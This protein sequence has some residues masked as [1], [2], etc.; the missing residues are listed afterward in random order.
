[1]SPSRFICCLSMLGML[2]AGAWAMPPVQQQAGL[3]RS[4]ADLELDYQVVVDAN[5]L[6]MFVTNVGS[7]ARDNSSLMGRI[8]GLY[9]PTGY[10]W[11]ALYSGGLWLGA[12]VAGSVRVSVAG[13]PPHTYSPGPMKDGTY[14]PDSSA[15]KVYKISRELYE[16][17]FYGNPRPATNVQ[18]QEKWDNYH[19]WP[20]SMGA[21]TY[22][23]G[24][25]RFYGDQT[26]WC[27]F[28]D[29]DPSTHY[30]KVGSSVG[31]G[32]EIQQTTF[33]LDITN[34]LKH[35]IFVRYLLINKGGNDLDSMYAT[36]WADPDIGD[37]KD[38]LAGCDTELDLGYAYNAK[39]VDSLYGV[40]P[41]AVGFCLLNGPLVPSAADS[42]MLHWE[43]RQG[44]RNLPMTAFIGTIAD[45][46]PIADQESYWYMQGLDA[47]NEGSAFLEPGTPYPTTFLFSGD[48]VTGSGWVD[49]AAI[50]N[51]SVSIAVE[52]TIHDW[53]V[54]IIPPR[55]VFES[56]DFYCTW[57]ISSDQEG[58]RSR[59]DYLGHIGTGT[60][61]MQI[62]SE[63]YGSL[64]YDWDTHYSTAPTHA[65]FEVWN[66]GS[67]LESYGDDRRLEIFIDDVV[68]DGKWSPGDIIYFWEEDYR[69]TPP[70]MVTP[71]D[72]ALRIGRIIIN[73][74]VPLEGNTIR[75]TS[76]EVA[77]TL[78]GADG[79]YMVSAGPFHMAPGDTQ[80]V[81]FAV[82]VGAG[83]DYLQSVTEL[84]TNT[85]AVQAAWDAGFDG[86]HFMHPPTPAPDTTLE[87]LAGEKIS[88]TVMAIDSTIGDT[89]AFAVDGLPSG[90]TLT[91]ALPLKG[92]PVT[93]TFSWSPDVAQV[94]VHELTFSVIDQNTGFTERYSIKINVTTP[95]NPSAFLHPPTP[96]CDTAFHLVAGDTLEFTVEAFDEDKLD[97]VTLT[98][99]GLPRG[100]QLTPALPVTDNPVQTSLRWVP[101]YTQ[102]G[103]H[104]LT[105]SIVDPTGAVADTCSFTV[106]VSS[107]GLA[108]EFVHPPTPACDTT[109]T[110]Q[111]GSMV[112]FSVE[113]NDQ[114]AA[115]RVTLS[116][117]GIPSGSLLSNPL[118]VT[119]NP[120]TTALSWQPDYSQLGS[121]KID[122]VIIDSIDGLSA[123]CSITLNVVY[124]GLPPLFAHPPTPECDTTFIIVARD[125]VCFTVRAYDEIAADRVT[126]SANGLPASAVVRPVLPA[127]G[128]P[129]SAQLCWRP[130]Y[131]DLGLYATTF[132]AT[133]SIDGLSIQ[134][135]FNFEV[136]SAGIAPE[137]RH[138]PT[139]ACDTTFNVNVGDTVEFAVEVVDSIDV[140]TVTLSAEGLPENAVITPELPASGNPVQ[141]SFFW[142]PPAADVGRYS[143][144]FTVVD[145]I[146]DLSAACGIGIDV[147]QNT[148]E[149]ESVTPADT[150]MID[151]TFSITF[152][153]P[154]NRVSVNN[155]EANPV[156]DQSIEI[157][158]SYS[159]ADDDRTIIFHPVN[160]LPPVT[161]LQVHLSGVVG[162]EGQT[163]APGY[164]RTVVFQTGYGVFPGDLNNDGR[165]D[166]LD[167]LPIAVHWRH[168]G[169]AM[170][171]AQQWRTWGLRPARSWSPAGAVY[172]DADGNGIVDEIDLFPIGHH[173][174]R[175]H[176]YANPVAGADG[177][178]NPGEYRRELQEFLS[179]IGGDDTPFMQNVRHQ[180]E[181]LLGVPAIPQDFHLGQ[182]H[183]N[184][185]NTETAITFMLPA[186]DDIT[187]IVYNALG[188]PVRVLARGAYPAGVHTVRWDGHDETDTPVASGLYFYTLT[189]EMRSETRKMLLLK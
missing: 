40:G 29:A 21:P 24:R 125:S 38:D 135:P 73:G 137:F 173:W 103:S 130:T 50:I 96:A 148:L 67:D 16:N 2:C 23:N 121:H 112:S 52:Q 105:F 126:L 145:S 51:R 4:V 7:F 47:K 140:E 64:Y 179:A 180:L 189:G 5:K 134:C 61:E 30:N 133:D 42:A 13:Y 157:A 15:F 177:A 166:S 169:P 168:T 88:F 68:P 164:P 113:A 9:F 20:A 62:L 151:S 18:A 117:T 115:D 110:V 17:G 141:V 65:P 188:R 86:P 92:N 184:P 162:T 31:L 44:Y 76:A 154:V 11:T 70:L 6:T 81:A 129:V 161:E 181:R 107:A 71:A 153:Y 45:T 111:A 90:A 63:P 158:G 120:V 48:P 75:F 118:P 43:W 156:I 186:P 79:R 74:S 146:D 116:A 34:P 167:V 138:L 22:P 19:N 172:A 97:Q 101:D 39:D 82:V 56:C 155:G 159:F 25:P 160:L 182:N 183:P 122:F 119:G 84:R 28:N 3:Y 12:Q 102:L 78:P 104:L 143:I 142:V 59:F 171:D 32:V 33:A 95:N 152:N 54:E 72:T 131:N 36:L 49:H 57:F 66:L 41:P 114:V 149:I 58:D 91:P 174:Q 139:P 10:D 46:D 8:D 150:L 87:V 136:I 176:G 128:N 69:G 163:W 165:V 123:Q 93:T 80:E 109:I 60:W 35:C 100:A 83:M 26:L 170:E 187:L 53:K 132:T 77:D 94:D 178:F 85:S 124:A 27:V 98:V 175:T 185:F 127:R 147:T 37:G 1:M 106:Y 55:D 144:V 108:P 99:D 89:I 14:L